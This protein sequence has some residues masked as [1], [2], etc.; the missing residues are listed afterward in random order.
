[1]LNMIDT[2]V[3]CWQANAG[4]LEVIMQPTNSLVMTLD[5][6][7]DLNSIQV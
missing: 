5:W 6:H 4:K 3:H 7:L 2:I 1:M